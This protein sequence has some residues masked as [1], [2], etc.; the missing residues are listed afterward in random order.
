MYP[1]IASICLFIGAA[2][3]CIQHAGKAAP[4]FAPSDTM[5]IA[6]SE[7]EF[8]LKSGQKAIDIPLKNLESKPEI[9]NNYVW[10]IFDEISVETA[11]EGVYEVYINRSR[12][13]GPT[14]DNLKEESLLG[15]LN[16]YNLTIP[17]SPPRISMKIPDRM[18]FLFSERQSLQPLRITVLFRGNVLPNQTEVE[19]TGKLHF[20]KVRVVQVRQ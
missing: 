18:K 7:K 17:N 15:K 13:N 3:S 12:Q 10:L 20:G 9:G 4:I 5:T 6:A 1:A 14:D 8:I 2:S 19:H 16:L 11:G